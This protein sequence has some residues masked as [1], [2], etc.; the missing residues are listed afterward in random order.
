[1]AATP[2]D[3][4][5]AFP[6]M[7]NAPPAPARR[8]A[9]VVLLVLL[10]VGA[11]V[12]FGGIACAVLSWRSHTV[13]SVSMED[14]LKV[15]ERIHADRTSDVRRGD[16]VIVRVPEW[17]S[18][19]GALIK[20]VIGVGGDRVVC[21]DA[22]GRVTVNG[23]TLAEDYVNAAAPGRALPFDVSVPPGRLWL[24]GDHREVSYDSRHHRGD[25]G[26]GT[27]A[28]SDVAARVFLVGGRS[29]GTPDTF[30]RDGLAESRA[31]PPLP[32]VG[33]MVAATGLLVL[34]AAAL[35]AFVRLLRRTKLPPHLAGQPHPAGSRPTP[36]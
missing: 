10:C 16:V 27:V 32:V 14:T 18:G 35:M 30:S 36:P 23:K 3:L 29:L 1:M 26:G 17:N 20:R 4:A 24:M 2:S 11:V 34:L 22:Q 12:A 25:P 21:C 13:N 28:E 5:L 6:F 33:L 9:P 19:E 31:F 15:G 8:R 7:R